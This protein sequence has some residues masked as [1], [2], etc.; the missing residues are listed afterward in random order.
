MPSP[1][2]DTGQRWIGVVNWGDSRTMVGWELA[3][4]RWCSIPLLCTSAH[5]TTGSYV[6]GRKGRPSGVSQVVKRGMPGCNHGATKLG[7]L[8]RRL[9]SSAPKESVHMGSVFIPDREEA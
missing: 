3:R 9:G 7:H 4:M 2:I 6:N 1:G 5:T 8:C